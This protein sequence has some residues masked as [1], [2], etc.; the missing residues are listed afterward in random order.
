MYLVP[1]NLISKIQF[2]IS[3]KFHSISIPDKVRLLKVLVELW[4]FIYE[5]QKQDDDS[6]NLKF[7]TQ[8]MGQEIN[9]KFYIKI[10]KKKIG[11][12]LLLEVLEHSKTIKINSNYLVGKYSYSYKILTEFIG[13]D[14][15]EIDL[16]F[17]KIYSN[18]KDKEYW[19]DN[20]IKHHHQ[21]K[22]CY[23][24]KIDITKYLQ[25]MKSNVG[26]KLKPIFE[27]GVLK[28]RIL[29]E[30]R[31]FDYLQT[32]LKINL[33]NLWF[34]VSEQGRFYNSTTNLSYTALPFSKLNNREIFE[35]D[36]PNCQPTLLAT[37]INNQQYKK[38]C[39][40]AIFYDRMADLLGKERNEFKLLSYKYIFFTNN[41]LNSG[42]IYDK[43][44]E[45]YPGLI[46]EVNQLRDE[47][48]IAH[49]MQKIESKIMVDTIGSIDSLTSLLRHD[50]IYVCQEDYEMV[51]ELM[52]SEFKKLGLNIKIKK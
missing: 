8:I 24:L 33:G 29:T 3:I 40:E 27:N 19:L 12:K 5:K 16:D 28:E 17:N 34:K 43:L 31:I 32:A 13:T 23:L 42:D 10:N 21:I 51:K 41:Q 20:N 45:L 47:I 25:W 26:I 44:E 22:N 37:L 39:E 6:K 35:L 36:I 11:Y 4:L 14:Y 30:E 18:F 2:S 49:E 15:E 46:K 52:I 1:I 48:N 7:F 9:G 38:D 50:A